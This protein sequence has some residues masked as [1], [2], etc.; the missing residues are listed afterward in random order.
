MIVVPAI[1]LR[2]GRVVRL[3]Q[4]DPGRVTVYGADP[5]AVA[6]RFQ[7]AGAPLLHVVDLDAALGTGS[8]AEAVRAVCRAVGIPVQV[9]GGLRT[10]ESV[11]EALGAGAARAVLGTAAAADPSFVARCVDRHGDRI[12]VA[13]DVRD[14][15]VVV[16]GWREEAGA[17]EELVP[18]LDAA[19]APRYLVT[20]VAADGRLEGPDLALYGRV[21]SLTDRP[22]LAS[23]G[24]RDAADLRALAALGVEGAVV[25]RALYE[26][27][28]SLAEL[29]AVGG[30]P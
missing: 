30:P 4:G 23:G 9:G 10:L 1:D 24:V 11:E 13:V 25:G 21:R 3:V 17:L 27:T 7:A 14:G 19:G 26:G 16:K 8:N 18:A 2:G 29:A 28:L 5:V 22:V 20:A 6:R 12:V 15:R